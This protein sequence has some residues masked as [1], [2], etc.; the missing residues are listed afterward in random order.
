ET[1]ASL[2]AASCG[3]GGSCRSVQPAGELGARAHAEL[4]VDVGQ[5]TGDRPLAEEQG[6]GDLP[7]RP[8]VGDQGGDSAF[9]RGQPFLAPAPGNPSELAARLGRPAG[10]AD[11]LER[12][13]S[14]LDGVAGRPLLPCAP[15]NDA[16][17]KE[18][19][20]PAEGI[21]DLLVLRDG[22]LRAEHGATDVPPGGRDETAA[23]S[24]VRDHPPNAEPRRTRLPHIEESNGANEP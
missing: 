8:A 22:P 6:G 1:Q 10:G 17:C 15:T 20:S 9:G 16:E 18:R 19:S 13:E 14:C 21:A 23:S 2:T 7:V 4:G 11:D 3:T 12:F 24:H 5:V